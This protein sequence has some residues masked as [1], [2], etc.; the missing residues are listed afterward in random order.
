LTEAI[1]KVL[2]MAWTFDISD[3]TY[4]MGDT[5]CGCGVFLEDTNWVANIVYY[6]N[7]YNIGPFQDR[8]SALLAAEDKLHRIK[9]EYS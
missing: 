6:N 2:A 3:E 4:K 7:I 8:H 5:L 1:K 9:Q